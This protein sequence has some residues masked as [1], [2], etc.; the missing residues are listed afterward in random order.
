MYTYEAADSCD[1]AYGVDGE[2]LSPHE[3][4]MLAV[5]GS[6]GNLDYRT[7]FTFFVVAGSRADD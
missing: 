3:R 2:E 5:G 4:F 1:T 6:S 7:N